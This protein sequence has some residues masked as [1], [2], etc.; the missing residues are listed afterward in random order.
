MQKTKL[1]KLPLG[2]ISVFIAPLLLPS[3][4]LATPD[5]LWSGGFGSASSLK[6]T[7]SLSSTYLSDYV[8][9]GANGWNGISSKV[10]L[11]QVSSGTY[12]IRVSTQSD[13]RYGVVGEMIAYCPS[14]SGYTKCGG[15]TPWGSAQVFGYTNQI[16]NFSLTKTQIISSVYSHEFGHSLSLGHNDSELPAVMTA[17]AVTTILPQAADKSHLKSKWGN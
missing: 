17:N 2:L 6:W 5:H 1:K 3:S 8:I 12:Q 16:A 15:Y 11:T 4:S 14:G 10:N 9:P 7:S 13:P